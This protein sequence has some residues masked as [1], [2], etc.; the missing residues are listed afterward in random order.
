MERY[1][2]LFRSSLLGFIDAASAIWFEIKLLKEARAILSGLER[3]KEL[4]AEIS[5]IITVS[6]CMNEESLSH[7][8]TF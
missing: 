1:L 6:F 8:L 3:E 5:T 7:F 4:K 2:F